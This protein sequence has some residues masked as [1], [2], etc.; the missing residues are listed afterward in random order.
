MYVY[1]LHT[2]RFGVADPK[3]DLVKMRK[4]HTQCYT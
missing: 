3:M 4:V 2:C 1:L